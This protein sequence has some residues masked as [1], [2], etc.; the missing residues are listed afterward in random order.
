MARKECREER[1][2]VNDIKEYELGEATVLLLPDPM[3]ASH[4]VR[5][6]NS[7]FKFVMNKIEEIKSKAGQDPVKGKEAEDYQENER[8]Q[9]WRSVLNELVKSREEWKE[10]DSDK[11]VDLNPLRLKL[12]Q[13]GVVNLN[14]LDNLIVCNVEGANEL[15]TIEAIDLINLL[16]KVVK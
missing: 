11:L 15:S 16:K 8:Y 14:L 10:L 7:D 1:R 4:A 2:S 5:W 6:I 9:H 3:P 13:K 12:L